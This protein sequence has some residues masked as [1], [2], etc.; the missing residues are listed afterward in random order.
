[1]QTNEGER[2]KT[3]VRKDRLDESERVRGEKQIVG[4]ALE[5]WC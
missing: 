3:A 4:G 2:T 5:L 1:M